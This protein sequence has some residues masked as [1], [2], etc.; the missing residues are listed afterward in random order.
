MD[1]KKKTFSL[2]TLH[3]AV[4]IAGAAA[5]GAISAVCIA[6]GKDKKPKVITEKSEEARACAKTAS[7]KACTAVRK[8]DAQIA[9]EV[10]KELAEASFDLSDDD[11]FS[12]RIEAIF[13]EE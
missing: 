8:S 9:A 10:E 5:V 6:L 3:K 4:T 11:S 2:S 12:K 7:D 1:D 13:S